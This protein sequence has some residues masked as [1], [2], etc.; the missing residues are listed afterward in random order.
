MCVQRECKQALQERPPFW[1]AFQCKENLSFDDHDGL[2]VKTLD[3]D[4]A[5]LRIKS[6]PGRRL[7]RE[8]RRKRKWN[9]D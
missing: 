7:K 5:G 1:K 3:S 2:V 9:G 4:A 6:Q 8:Q